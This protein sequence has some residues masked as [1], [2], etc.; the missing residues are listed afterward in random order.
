[1][2]TQT[3][4]SILKFTLCSAVLFAL[5]MAPLAAVSGS[6]QQ[7]AAKLQTASSSTALSVTDAQEQAQEA[8]KAS[9]VQPARAVSAPVSHALSAPARKESQPAAPSGTAVVVTATAGTMGLTNYATVGAAFAAIN[10]GTH[11]GAIDVA[12]TAN[13]TEGATP[14]T[15]NSSG[16]GS[17]S[18]TSVA[19]HL[20]PTADGVSVSGNPVTGFGVIQL[21][22][23]DNVTIDGDNPNSGGTNRDLTISNTAVATV[24]A[25]S[26]V[27]IATSSR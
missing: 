5:G 9:R 27:R 18:Y 26:V 24:T 2:K 7:A 12:I 8:A 1:M 3:T 13:T 21:N 14:A 6:Q 25:N 4:Q 22:G 23:A 11:Q 20:H 19:I 17:A 16:A 15:L 10:A